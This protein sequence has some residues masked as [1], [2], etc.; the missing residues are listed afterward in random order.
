MNYDKN[1]IISK[2]KAL[3]RSDIKLKTQFIDENIDLVTAT[4][5]DLVEIIENNGNICPECN[6]KMEFVD[7]YTYCYRRFSFKKIDI[8]KIYSKDNIILMCYNC[9][10]YSKNNPKFCTNCDHIIELPTMLIIDC[11]TTGLPFYPN[12]I[13]NYDR[14]RLLEFAYILY[15]FNQRK[16]LS[17]YSCLIKPDNFEVKATEIH[18]I[19]TDM[20]NTGINI[21]ELFD[22]LEK[23]INDFHIIMAHNISFDIK[24]LLSETHRYNRINLFNKILD[25]KLLCTSKIGAR[26]SNKKKINGKNSGKITLDELQEFLQLEKI[27][28]HRA[29]TDTEACLSC[30]LKM[31]EMNSKTRLR[32][33]TINIVVQDD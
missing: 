8:K 30:F 21:D 26:F 29:L 4:V 33:S 6:I 20:A 10:K 22:H 24:V 1:K 12:Y 7:C 25:K 19:T 15:D 27:N 23:I 13:E 3:R 18:G 9:S 11:E 2:V 5:D 17:R 16:E 32:Y 31:I 28:T 14:C